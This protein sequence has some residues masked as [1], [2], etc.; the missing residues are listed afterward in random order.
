MLDKFPGEE[1]NREKD[2]IIARCPFLRVFAYGFSGDDYPFW[3]EKVQSMMVAARDNAIVFVGDEKVEKDLRTFF[4]VSENQKI[5]DSSLQKGTKA[6]LVLSLLLIGR[7]IGN[8]T[9]ANF[10]IDELTDQL[11]NMNVLNDNGVLGYAEYRMYVDE[12]VKC[13]AIWKNEMET[14]VQDVWKEEISKLN[15]DF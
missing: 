9:D 4:N 3:F 14:E 11:F 6:G 1:E 13:G 8:E 7:E 15:L 5:F 10:F 2:L 12:V